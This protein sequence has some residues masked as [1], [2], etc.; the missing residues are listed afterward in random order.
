M[1]A[2]TGGNVLITLGTG[3]MNRREE[4]ESGMAGEHAYAVINLKEENGRRLFLIKNPWSE[5]SSWKDSDNTRYKD[6]TIELSGNTVTQ[7]RLVRSGIFWMEIND[8]FQ[9]FETI[10]LSWNPAFFSNRQDIHFSWNLDFAR[11]STGSFYR[12]PQ[13][14]VRSPKGGTLWLLL[15][16]HLRGSDSLSCEDPTNECFIASF[17]SLYAFDI[18]GSRA[19]ISDGY[20]ARS[21]Y[22]DAPNTLLR[23]ELPPKSAY[24]V[25]I[26]EQDTP[27]STCNFTLSAFSD[28][29]TTLDQAKD[30][31]SHS[32]VQHSAWTLS[33]SGG[34][35][36]SPT[37]HTN[38]QFSLEL[39]QSS[40]L[41][42][43]LEA[44][45]EEIPV[46]VKLLW[47][48]GER[49]MEFRTRDVVGDSG[50]YRNGSALAEIPDV[51]PG[52]YTMICST[53][54]QD[55]LT[56]FSLYV[57]AMSEC[58]TKHIPLE[59]AGR[60]VCRAPI[61]TFL[62]GF[63]RLLTPLYISRITRLR[64]HVHTITAPSAIRSP[65]RIALEYGQGPNKQVLS[66]TGDGDFKDTTVA[67]RTKDVDILPHMCQ[68]QGVWLVIERA[69]GSYLPSTEEV[70]IDILSD[71]QVD[72]GPWG[73]ERDD[74][75]DQR[76]G[77][78]SSP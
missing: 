52:I 35:S 6:N 41:A 10:Y 71:Q 40:D 2:Y 59:E 25:V 76:V 57:R 47:M 58:M 65:I 21:S 14:V 20:L 42:L 55:Q 54:E 33:T 5:A 75:V 61:A 16:K 78:M 9:H 34:N 49:A 77:L 17:L 63:D 39:S 38:P 8:I 22:V 27:I 67:L 37:Y 1:K 31:Y 60:L 15:S 70:C 29:P 44:E 3:K 28:N 7:S 30:R 53:F 74:P 66:I 32:T 12:N 45:D 62:V 43:F 23:L 36:S 11:S 26:S 19:F 50:E 51:Q 24:T 46:H 64:A 73:K 68:N 4:G 69:G 48:N 72:L 13:Y 18:G 56:K